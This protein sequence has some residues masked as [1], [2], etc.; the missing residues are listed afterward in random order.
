ERA[1][2]AHGGK[3]LRTAV[4]DRYVVEA[5]RKNKLTLGGEQSGHLVFLDHA[6]T[7]DGCVAALQILAIM[8]REGRPMSELSAVMER[9]PQVLE[10]ILL[11]KRLPLES[12]PTLSAGIAQ[13]EKRLKKSGRVL[14]RWS[15]T[16]PKL[17]IMAEGPNEDVLR[18][19][20]GELCAAA[21]K[22]ASK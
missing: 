13:L 12:M 2:E 8:T 16:E 11:P 10:S 20:V 22:D 17:R 5:M 19:A 15:G 14:V 7:G 1:L 6:T 9:A 3:L 18:Q 4:G 21:K